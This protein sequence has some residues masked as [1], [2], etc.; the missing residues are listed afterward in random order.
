ME[1]EKIAYIAADKEELHDEHCD[2]GGDN[3][4]PRQLTTK[5]GNVSFGHDEP[6]VQTN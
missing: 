2:A 6:C 3:K 4:N 1:K 5:A